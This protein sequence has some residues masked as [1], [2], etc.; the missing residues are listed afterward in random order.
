MWNF[1]CFLTIIV[2]RWWLLGVIPHHKNILGDGN[3]KKYRF[4]EKAYD[5]INKDTVD[6]KL[7]IF[8]AGKS[9]TN[10]MDIYRE[11]YGSQ[12]DL[13]LYHQLFCELH[14]KASITSD[15]KYYLE[16]T[17]DPMDYH[18]LLPLDWYEEV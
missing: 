16:S 9:Y 10:T 1:R 4:T 8:K 12:I 3:M 13:N 15:Y 17:S 11:R 14:D 2:V 6:R 5:S 7:G 18:L